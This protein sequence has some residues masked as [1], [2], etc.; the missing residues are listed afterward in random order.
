II[1]KGEGINTE[2]KTASFALPKSV[3]ETVCAMLNRTGGHIFLGVEDDGTISGVVDTCVPEMKSNFST[4]VNNPKQLSPKYY[5][6]LEAYVIKGKTILHCYVP[7]SSQVHSYLGKIFDRNEDG[8]FNISEN[9]DLVRQLHIKKQGSFSENTI[10]PVIQLSDLREDLIQRARILANN[11]RPGHPWMEMTDEQLL[12]SAGLW[13]KDWKSGEKGFTL[14]AALLLGKDYLIQQ[15][16][17]H[18]KTDAI[19][20]RENTERYDDRAI[21]KTNLIESYDE[22]MAF[23]GKHLPDKF[24]LEKDQRL[25]LR[26][27]IFREVITNT[28]IHREYFNAFPA[29]L[30]IENDLV[31]VEN[32]NRPHGSGKLIINSFTPSPKN[33]VLGAFFREIGRADELGSGLRKTNKYTPLY[34][35]GA[36]PI[37]EEGDVFSMQIPLKNKITDPANDPVNDPVNDAVN[38]AVNNKFIDGTLDGTINGI[39]DGAIDG[40][41]KETKRKLSKL[42]KAIIE[43]EGRR[44]PDYKN[45]TQLGSERTI[46]RYVELLKEHNIIEFKGKSPK[47]GG[48]FITEVFKKVL[49]SKT[50]DKSNKK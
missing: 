19:L 36:K 3:Y 15:I 10:Y 25:S 28:L 46:E 11:N 23:I 30:I 5:L 48:Y 18:Y 33:P 40:T 12:H 1:A 13:K 47:T 42:L 44:I 41:T 7:E 14:A 50:S 39:I 16:L 17:P 43:N 29:R 35:D 9:Q 49:N 37:F 27:N 21:V 22:L 8:D 26:D 38:N 6:S 2:F 4:A 32:W 34:S 45:A 20:R 31:F 24:H